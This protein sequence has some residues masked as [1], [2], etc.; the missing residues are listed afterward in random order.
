[1]AGKSDNI[2]VC[3]SHQLYLGLIARCFE[4]RHY[5]YTRPLAVMQS[6]QDEYTKI[7]IMKSLKFTF[8]LVSVILVTSCVST[9]QSKSVVTID[10]T[11]IGT[12]DSLIR[13]IP[14]ST[15]TL[16][17]GFNIGMTKAQY[18][19]QIHKLRNEGKNISYSNS[20][21]ITALGRKMELGAGYTFNTKISTKVNDEIHTGNGEYF[22]D[23]IYNN[24][25]ELVELDILP[26]EE[27]D[28]YIYGNDSK[29]LESKIKN[30][31][32][33]LKDKT[34]ERALLDYGMTQSI[35]FVHRKENLLIYDYGWT[36]NYIDIN[37]VYVRFRAKLIEQQK[38]IKE[39]NK[40]QF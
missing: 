37:A 30:S 38:I 12:L 6:A 8:L 16:F 34:L 19:N 18:K 40:V 5:A 13:T 15:D 21:I 7:K 36:I 9:N 25:G 17:L 23:P 3:S 10:Y 29:W 11:D 22:L 35:S 2:K 33:E 28:K 4:V 32:K 31:S 27:W 20:N 1:M 39:S 14:Q 26:F 24:N